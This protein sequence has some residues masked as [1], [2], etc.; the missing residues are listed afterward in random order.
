MKYFLQSFA[1]LLL[2]HSRRGVVSY[3]RKYVHEVLVNH[4]FKLAEEKCVVRCT[5]CPAITIAVDLG[6]K[7]TKLKAIKMLLAQL[8][9]H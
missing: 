1:S 6:H 5:D 3:K 7:V 4:L 2:N 9:E 8:V